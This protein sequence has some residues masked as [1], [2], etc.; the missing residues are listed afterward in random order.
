MDEGVVNAKLESL[1][2]CV[3]RLE[4]H[5][6]ATAD[7]LAKDIDAQD[8]IAL[9]LSRSVQVCVELAL[10]RLSATGQTTPATMGAAF[11]ELAQIGTINTDLAQRMKSA[12][13]FRN[14][15]VHQYEAMDWRIVHAICTK[16]LDDFRTFAR[17]IVSESD[18]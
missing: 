16:H 12:V 10:H 17:L 18:R 11:D 5:C 3:A 13:G 4:S 9:N 6:T 1:R 7:E 8:I 15:A 14:L 2:R